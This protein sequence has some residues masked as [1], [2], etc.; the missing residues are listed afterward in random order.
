MCKHDFFCQHIISVRSLN[1]ETV[2]KV[3][4][5]PSM[6]KIKLIIDGFCQYFCQLWKRISDVHLVV[7]FSPEILKEA[8]TFLKLYLN[9]WIRC[10]DWIF[11]VNFLGKYF[12]GIFRENLL[13]EFFGGIFGWIFL[14]NFLGEFF[15]W[16]LWWNFFGEFYGW[17]FWVNFMGDSFPWII[18]LNF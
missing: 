9:S 6:E 14:G 7:L 3:N 8:N 15:G 16:I 12:G 18:W 11:W 4:P 17:I 1:R 2:W 5:P 10:F 13:S